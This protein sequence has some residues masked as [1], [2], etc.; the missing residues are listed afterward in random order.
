ME[1][2]Y[3][4][5]GK[6]IT[7]LA[8]AETIKSCKSFDN[9]GFDNWLRK[10]TLEPRVELFWWRLSRF[11]IP[12]NEF[13][14]FRMLGNNDLCASGCL[15]VENCAHVIV[16][17]KSLI[18][19]IGMLRTWSFNIPF[20]SSLKE[21]LQQLIL[22]SIAKLDIV[23]IYCTAIFLAWNRRNDVKH[24]NPILP[25]LIIASNILI[26]T[27]NKYPILVNW[28]A[29]L[30]RESETSWH[31]PPLGWI[32]INV[33]ASLLDS[34]S[35]SIGGVVR[36]SKGSLLLA[37]GKQTLHWDINQLELEAVYSLKDFIH[38]WM[39]DCKGLIIEGDNYNVIKHLYD[40][41][42]KSKVINQI[43]EKISFIQDFNKV[44]FHH[45]S[46]NC[47]R[48]ADLCATLALNN[49][50]CFYFISSPDIPRSLCCLMKKEY[51]DCI[52]RLVCNNFFLFSS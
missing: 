16:H 33:D 17:C 52:L 11:S 26:T 39:F 13:L 23:K 41:V 1:L 46:R 32:K 35:V 24:G 45:T 7:S 38:D 43:S 42:T 10:L 49:S 30:L 44:I 6:S 15:V 8:Y 36:D 9:S 4:H 37:F 47:N 20:F 31:P 3:Q 12:T 29:F 25:I 2:L 50:F 28:D 14:K 27:T 48:V 22:L 19:I 5:Y 21:C 40:S 34:N 18:E 51:E